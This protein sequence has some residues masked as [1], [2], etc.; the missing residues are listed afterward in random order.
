MTDKTMKAQSEDAQKAIAI[1]Y[2]YKEKIDAMKKAGFSAEEIANSSYVKHLKDFLAMDSD[3]VAKY[4]AETKN[5]ETQKKARAERLNYER[6]VYAMDHDPKDAAVS[7]FVQEQI[8]AMKKAGFSDEEIAKSSY[9]KNL[10]TFLKMD[11][12]LIA[13]YEAETNDKEAQ[14]RARAE[15]VAYEKEVRANDVAINKM[16]PRLPS[17]P[18]IDLPSEPRPMTKREGR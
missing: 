1:E 10:P 9:I 17:D 12:G 18:A 14:K 15:R 11:E 5:K 7:Y 16:T 8:D 6:E 3:I 13:K 2:F 4:Q